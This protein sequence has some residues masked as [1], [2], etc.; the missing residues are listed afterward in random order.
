MHFSRTR[1]HLPTP[2]SGHQS[3]FGSAH[4]CVTPTSPRASFSNGTIWLPQDT[5]L[6]ILSL[7][8]GDLSWTTCVT[9]FTSIDSSRSSDCDSVNMSMSSCHAM[10]WD[11]QL[12]YLICLPFPDLCLSILLAPLVFR[13]RSVCFT[14][15]TNRLLST[16]RCYG[17][18]VRFGSSIFPDIFFDVVYT[19]KSRICGTFP[20]S[21]S[22]YHNEMGTTLRRLWNFWRCRTFWDGRFCHVD[23]GLLAGT[24]QMETSTRRTSVELVTICQ[25]YRGVRVRSIVIVHCRGFFSPCRWV[26]TLTRTE[27]TRLHTSFIGGNLM[28]TGSGLSQMSLR[29]RK[30]SCVISDSLSFWFLSDVAVGWWHFDIAS[31]SF[32]RVAEVNSFVCSIRKWFMIITSDLIK[33][34]RASLQTSGTCHTCASRGT[35]SDKTSTLH[36]W[37]MQWWAQSHCA[38]ILPRGHGH[39]RNNASHLSRPVSLIGGLHP[40]KLSRLR[41]I[42]SG[43]QIRS[44]TEWRQHGD[45]ELDTTCSSSFRRLWCE[46]HVQWCEDVVSKL[47]FEEIVFDALSMVL[48]CSEDMFSKSEELST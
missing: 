6:H 9:W 18:I 1:L 39:R 36:S 32:R 30:S 20:W 43:K 29:N 10:Q 7:T 34:Y 23:A 4:L 37:R 47:V 15:E 27:S 46:D 38:H 22:V 33:A 8:T 42:L 28:R 31:M 26:T 17:H 5:L 16:F 2:N 21:W 48:C 41:D 24:G 19:G 35:M 13:T 40:Q 12:L 14:T 11:F 44:H 3:R 45:T 25:F